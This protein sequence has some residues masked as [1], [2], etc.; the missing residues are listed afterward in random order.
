MDKRF[1]YYVLLGLLIGSVFG[2]GYASANG[3]TFLGLWMGVLIGIFVGWFLAVA[4]L[5]QR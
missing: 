2:F 3:N 5:H 4:D 1:G